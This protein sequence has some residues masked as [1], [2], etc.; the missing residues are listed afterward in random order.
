[1]GTYSTVPS[2]A[3]GMDL[4]MPGPTKWRGEK[5]LTAVR[6]HQISEDVIDASARRVLR[7]AETLGRFE[8]PNE[9]SEI[10]REDASRDEF[11][12]KA[13]AEG[14]VLLKNDDNV[15]S[16]PPNASILVVGQHARITSLGG[17]GSAKVNSLK[18]I[19]LVEGLFHAGTPFKYEAGVPVFAA[20]PQAE[21][22][23]LSRTSNS[24]PPGQ[25]PKPFLLE[26]FNGSHIGIRQVHSENIANAEYMIKEK[27]PSFLD[28]NYCTRMT[29]SIKPK[30]S[31]S[32]LF[33][34]ITTGTSTV[35][36]NNEKVYH[37]PQEPTLLPESFYFY[38][39]KIEHRFTSFLEGNRTHAIR[40]ES[41]AA[42]PEVL[43]KAS[44]R[45]FQGTSL[46]F[47]EH[48]SIPDAISSATEAARSADYTIICTGTTNEIESEGYDRETMDLTPDQYALIY[49]ITSTGSNTILINFSGAP[50]TISPF[51]DKV[52]VFLQAWFPGQECGHAITKVL[53]GEVNP[54]GRLPLSWP[55]RNEDNPAFPNF[56][57]D[58]NNII[59]YEEG[60]DVGYRY[61]DKESTPTPQFPFGFGLSYTSFN[62]SDIEI[63]SPSSLSPPTISPHDS[64]ISIR[65][66][67]NVLNSGSRPGKTVIQFYVSNLTSEQVIGHARP[68]KELKS[69]TKLH[70]EPGESKVVTADFDKYSVS[71]YDAADGR[72]RINPGLYEVKVGFS[73]EEIIGSVGFDV[74]EGFVWKGV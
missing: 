35:Y 20:V 38:K 29:F 4:E 47:F 54:C 14:M 16:L 57:C 63:S 34:I 36:V 22:A 39:A 2:L 6:E 71:F 67:C 69:F 30:T 62:I 21:A 32:H 72:W 19:S 9:D 41:W 12:I 44:G 45:V 51:I 13:A 11:I 28:S 43:T 27:W 15:L 61:Y 23:V 49:S 60:L 26:W 56:P 7:L 73:T 10:E 40:I 58:D 8:N 68:I 31:G 74:D 59:R 42:D 65:V 66:S 18:S 17:G 24:T 25:D 1:M 3:A 33:S 53:T 50:V 37:R 64:N 46:R 52:D 55:K 5:L 48:V 70:L